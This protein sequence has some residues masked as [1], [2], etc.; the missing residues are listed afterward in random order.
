MCGKL[1]GEGGRGEGATGS[2]CKERQQ[3]REAREPTAHL[4]RR[5]PEQRRGAATERRGEEP[6]RAER[7]R[8]ARLP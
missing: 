3:L 5:R 1:R 6:L 7:T 2:V 8:H 4:Q